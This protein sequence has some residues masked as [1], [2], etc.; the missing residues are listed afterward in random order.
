[1]QILIIIALVIAIIAVIFALQNLTVV[2]VSFFFWEAHS[3]LALV[4][5]ITL[6]VGVA[7]SLLASLPGM[8]RG[9]LNESSQKKRLVALEAERDTYRQ[10]AEAAEKEVKALEEQLASYSA[11]LEKHLPDETSQPPEA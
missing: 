5:L 8:I 4:L 1:M 6:A 2:T 7:I 3:S 11:E 10:R 9:K